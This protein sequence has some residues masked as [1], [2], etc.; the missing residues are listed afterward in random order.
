MD[1]GTAIGLLAGVAI[2]AVGVIRN[3]GG[4]QTYI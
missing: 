4:V 3:G 1:F 2:I